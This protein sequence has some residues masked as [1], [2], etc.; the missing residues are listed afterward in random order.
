[1]K[2]KIL[3]LFYRGFSYNQIRKELGCSKGTI[4]YHCSKLVND[5]RN[6]ISHSTIVRIR[7]LHASGVRINDICFE[8]GISAWAIRKYCGI[9]RKKGGIKKS[10][11]QSVI[12]WR[13]RMKVRAVEYKGGRCE[14]CGYD[15]CMA[16]LEFHHKNPL[17]KDFRISSTTRG[18]SKL[19][20]ELDKCSL[21]C[22]NCHR[23]LHNK[24]E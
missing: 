21:L 8:L 2:E 5:R 12:D 18:W 17:K 6:N 24:G 9:R 10:R 23:E 11:S 1:M 14:T 15:K 22:A 7:E 16:A 20:I 19:K 4:S 13:Q 3:D